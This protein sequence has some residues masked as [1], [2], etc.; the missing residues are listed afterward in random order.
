MVMVIVVIPIESLL[1]KVRGI[2][3]CCID[4]QVFI[5]PLLTF[6]SKGKDCRTTH[7]DVEDFR[8]Y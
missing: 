5:L 8:E 2:Q 7:F 3:P 1:F 6:H 4:I